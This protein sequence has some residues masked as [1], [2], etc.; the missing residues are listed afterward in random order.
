[1]K[2]PN[3]SSAS[4]LAELKQQKPGQ[5]PAQVQEKDDGGASSRVSPS[6]PPSQACGP[7]PSPHTSKSQLF[8]GNA[9]LQPRVK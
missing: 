9:L 3:S 8:P 4:L 5:V 6:P 2:V 7:L 1:M